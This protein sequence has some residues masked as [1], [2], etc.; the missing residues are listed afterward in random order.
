VNVTTDVVLFSN[1]A[2]TNLAC[3]PASGTLLL[4]QKSKSSNVLAL[5]YEGTICMNA[6]DG[7]QF[8]FSGPYAVNG[9]TS[10]GKFANA[11]GSGTF[12][13]SVGL[14]NTTT[15]GNINGTL[16]LP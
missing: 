5:D 11:I 8:V 4:T 10:L 16:Q 15:V 3:G 6:N 9:S 2:M 14:S 13:A 12:T 1:V 7:T